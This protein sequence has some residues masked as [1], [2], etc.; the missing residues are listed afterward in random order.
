MQASAAAQTDQT[1]ELRNQTEHLSDQVRIQGEESTGNSNARSREA[2][3]QFITARLNASSALLNAYIALPPPSGSSTSDYVAI[4]AQR[5]ELKKLTQEI[6]IL[7][8]EARLGFSMFAHWSEAERMAIR[9]YVTDMLQDAHDLL[10]SNE[11]PPEA[12]LTFNIAKIGAIKEDLKDLRE[13]YRARYHDIADAID[14]MANESYYTHSEVDESYQPLSGVE[15]GKAVLESILAWLQNH[16]NTT[17]AT[18]N[19][20]WSPGSGR[21]R[22]SDVS[23]PKPQ[24]GD[25][26]QGHASAREP[27]A[28]DHSR[29]HSAITGGLPEDN[30]KHDPDGKP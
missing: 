29:I 8:C 24:S 20:I 14:K 26:H 17:L 5:R 3:V 19:P 21:R 18:S 6:A 9:Q 28:D 13:R 22:R 23:P 27:T 10:S 15:D 7:R 1:V 16:L 12:T 2:R 25:P 11:H 4:F 30:E